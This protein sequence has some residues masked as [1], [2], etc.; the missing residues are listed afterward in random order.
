LVLKP[1]AYSEAC[2]GVI[3]TARKEMEEAEAKHERAN[4]DASIPEIKYFSLRFDAASV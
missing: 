3:A 4:V 1:Y 2:E